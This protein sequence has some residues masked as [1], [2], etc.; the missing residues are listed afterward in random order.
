LFLPGT[1]KKIFRS[2]ALLDYASTLLVTVIASVVTIIVVGWLARVLDEDSF[3]D[4]SLVQRYFGFLA[5]V[6]NLAF[7]FGF[8]KL[9]KSCEAGEILALAK[10]CRRAVTLWSLAIL[11]VWIGYVSVFNAFAVSSPLV[12]CVIFIWVIAQAQYHVSAPYA[13]HIGG[14]SQYLKLY[15]VARIVSAIAGLLVAVFTGLYWTFFIAYALVSQGYQYWMWS[16]NKSVIHIGKLAQIWQ[17][18]STRWLEGI[19]RAALPLV[20]VMLAQA[21]FGHKIAGYVAV[22]YTFVKSIESVLQPLVVSIMMRGASTVKKYKSILAS[23][24][25]TLLLCLIL[26]LSKDLVIYLFELLLG[27]RYFHL[28]NNAWMVLFSMGPIIS[29]NLLRATYDNDYKHSP[30]LLINCVCIVLAFVG[31]RFCN[32]LDDIS[33]LIIL[34]QLT[35]WFGYMMFLVCIPASGNLD[36]RQVN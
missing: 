30:L 34:V 27:E 33:V 17:F 13:R 21:Y 2:A 5:I 1:M 15:A 12:L 20:F 14:V 18:S 6:A 16:G 24:G 25:F 22:I 35:R 11:V 4:F 19:L 3:L 31:M 36:K 23:I 7:G 10:L 28:T 26:Y 9:S 29:L 32:D 8:I